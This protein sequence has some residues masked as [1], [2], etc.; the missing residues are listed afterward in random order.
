MSF[1]SRP[2]GSVRCYANR[3]NLVEILEFNRRRFRFG[4]NVGCPSYSGYA[5]SG[6]RAKPNSTTFLRFERFRSDLIAR[7]VRTF[8]DEISTNEKQRKLIVF[9]QIVCSKIRRKV[10]VSERL[11]GA[12]RRDNSLYLPLRAHDI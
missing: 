5:F 3:N 6:R 7:I 8:Y 12:T 11:A 4:L 1:I 2:L 10:R 9:I